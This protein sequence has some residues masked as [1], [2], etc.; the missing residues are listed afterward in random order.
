MQ[1]C[2]SPY[3][4][5]CYGSLFDNL[6][7]WICMEYCGAGSVADIMRLRNQ[8]LKEN[9][10]GTI[11]KYSLLGLEYLHEVRVSGCGWRV[12]LGDV[13]INGVLVLSD[14]KNSP[15]HQSR[16]QSN[17]SSDGRRTWRG[18]DG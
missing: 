18:V 10:I 2:D 11:L 5:K 16:P 3:I 12:E 1:Q 4:V 7:L 17:A 15:R 9:E 13:R 6:D 8:T 14:E